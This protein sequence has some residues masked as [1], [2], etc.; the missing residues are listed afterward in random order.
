M[1]TSRETRCRM[2]AREA[3]AQQSRPA[4]AN[5]EESAKSPDHFPMTVRNTYCG[6]LFATEQC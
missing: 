4:R 3:S 1:S 6:N 2:K 5:Q